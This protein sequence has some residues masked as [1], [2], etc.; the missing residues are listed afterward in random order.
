MIIIRSE[1]HSNKKEGVVYTL[2]NPVVKL[3]ATAI[4]KADP[5]FLFTQANFESFK[6]LHSEPFDL[7]SMTVSSSY[8]MNGTLLDAEKNKVAAFSGTYTIETI[9]HGRTIT[10]VGLTGLV[11]T[12]FRSMKIS[13]QQSF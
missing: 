11:H 8:T 6:E 10:T 2:G 5:G 9:F 12:P 3:L 4:E 1:S 13:D 7:S